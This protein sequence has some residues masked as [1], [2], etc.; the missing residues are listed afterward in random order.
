M[1]FSK[2]TVL[3]FVLC[4][5]VAGS[6]NAGSVFLETFAS[7]SANFTAN[8]PYWLDG[9]NESNGFIVQNTNSMPGW[10]SWISDPASI[11]NDVS[12]TGYFLMEGTQNYNWGGNTEFYIGPTF[13]VAPD[14]LYTVSFYATSADRI[15]EASLQPEID[16]SPLGSPVAPGTFWADYEAD[17]LP[18]G[19]QLFSFS[20]NSGSNT[21]ASVILNDFNPNGSGNDFA[22]DD[23]SVAAATP[24]PG[25]LA[26]AGLGFAA[27]LLLRKRVF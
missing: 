14:T 22:I 5:L 20:W 27:A 18:S 6:A 16:G 13:A 25:T 19:W 12:G 4:V 8:D 15:L 10:P 17:G 23:I 24:E 1:R 3:A 2:A 7:G 26:L 21:S 11:P 9:P